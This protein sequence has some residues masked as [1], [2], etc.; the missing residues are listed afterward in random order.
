MFPRNEKSKKRLRLQY[1]FQLWGV[2][3]K[4]IRRLK[5]DRSIGPEKGPQVV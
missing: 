4:D 2:V 5:S 1:P 3:G